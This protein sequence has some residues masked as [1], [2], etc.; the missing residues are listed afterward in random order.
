MKEYVAKDEELPHRQ[1]LVE[2]KA[3]KDTELKSAT[4]RVSVSDIMAQYNTKV[5]PSSSSSSKVLLIKRRNSMF[6]ATQTKKP[7]DDPV[8]VTIAS[9]AST[10]K[11]RRSSLPGHGTDLQDF[12]KEQGELIS[13]IEK[14][15]EEKDELSAKLDATGNVSAELRGLLDSHATEMQKVITVCKQQKDYIDELE[16]SRKKLEEE[17]EALAAISQKSRSSLQEHKMKLDK[18]KH[19]LS[20]L[21]RD[22]NDLR[23]KLEVSTKTQQRKITMSDGP[24]PLLS[25]TT[26]SMLE[27]FQS[28]DENVMNIDQVVEAEKVH[29][30]DSVTKNSTSATTKL[31]QY[32]ALQLERLESELLMLREALTNVEHENIAL[33]DKLETERQQAKESDFACTQQQEQLDRAELSFKAKIDE[34]A[35]KHTEEI[36]RLEQQLTEQKSKAALLD[37]MEVV[38]QQ[39]ETKFHGENAQ[40]LHK[41]ESTEA[42]AKS[43]RQAVDEKTKLLQKYA[44]ESEEAS[45]AAEEARKELE[46]LKAVSSSQIKTIEL[47]EETI[48]DQ[49]QDIRNL[50]NDKQSLMADLLELDSLK[51]TVERQATEIHSLQADK[52]LLSNDIADTFVL[53]ETIHNQTQEIVSLQQENETIAKRLHATTKYERLWQE[54]KEAIKKISEDKEKLHKKNLDLLYTTEELQMAIEGHKVQFESQRNQIVSLKNLVDGFS[55]NRDDNADVDI[56]KHITQLATLME[57]KSQAD[58]EIAALRETLEAQSEEIREYEERV[59]ALLQER[60][61]LLENQAFDDWSDC[62]DDD[63]DDVSSWNASVV[64][65][66][67]SLATGTLLWK[68]NTEAEENDDD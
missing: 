47:M 51:N 19:E 9:Q 31:S 27:D 61:A 68:E 64:A 21:K 42:E 12:L 13:Q 58:I 18:T 35:K 25:P 66:S 40:L 49:I 57:H 62:D 33:Q 23:K 60:D 50:E 10:I 39:A 54:Q 14:L 4:K 48:V 16:R 30:M 46:K 7:T 20:L 2:L 28:N 5:S 45:S 1:N 24:P 52:A 17:K 44:F 36:Q 6:G 53:K 41:L 22:Q 43:L 63:E 34:M 37:N 56:E 32:Q 29:R 38:V 15:E 65:S 67:L 3:R 26:Q 8:G 59:D 11:A 55:E